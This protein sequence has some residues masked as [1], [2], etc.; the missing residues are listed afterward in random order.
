MLRTISFAA[1]AAALL[2]PAAHAQ[3]DDKPA[4]PPAVKPVTV[5]IV[6]RDHKGAPI[7]GLSKDNFTIKVDGTVQPVTSAAPE[8]SSPVMY[9]FVVDVSRAQR[10]NIEEE[11]KAGRALIAQLKP[12]DTMFVVQ[13]ARQIELLQDPTADHAKLETALTELGTSSSSF[14]PIDPKDGTVDEEGRRIHSAGPVLYDAMFLA[15]DEVLAKKPGRH[16]LVVYSD[17]I[18]VGSKMA[19]SDA[20]ESILRNGVMIYSLYSQGRDFPTEQQHNTNRGGNNG[21]GRSGGG[22]PGGGGGGWPGGG[23]GYPGQYPSGGGNNPNGSGQGGNNPRGGNPQ[24]SRRPHEDGR[25]ALEKLST[26]TGGRLFDAGKHGA[27]DEDMAGVAQ[28]L[29]TAYWVTFTPQGP[30]GRHG[31]H[32]FDLQV[33]GSDKSKKVDV[34]TTD[35]YYATS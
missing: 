23:G 26:A 12:G 13:F 14:Q 15:S 19:L 1:L 5:P 25:G 34:Q 10:D 4:P 18:D 31:Y 32:P 11:R 35:G 33:Q 21:G 22:W 6:V 17:G 30:A 16:V 2:L 7:D 29:H 9:G 8:P 20:R 28:D 24:P 27:L 3:D